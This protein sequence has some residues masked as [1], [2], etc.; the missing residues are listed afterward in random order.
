MLVCAILLLIS[1]PDSRADSGAQQEPP[2][3]I[4]VATY[5]LQPDTESF[6]PVIAD[7]VRYRLISRGLGVSF[8]AGTPSI[9]V[10][11]AQARKAGAAITLICSYSVIGSQMSIS[12]QWR[13][14]QRKAPPVVRDEKGPLDLMLDSVILKALDDLLSSVQERV[15]QLAGLREAASRAQAKAPPAKDEGAGAGTPAETVAAKALPAVAPSSMHYSLSSGF[16]SFI[17]IGPASYYFSVGLFPSLLASLEFSTP[18]G[19]FA[20]GI[21][22]GVNFFSA[23]GPLDTATSFLIPLGPDVRYEIGDGAPLLAFAHVSGGPALLI[24]N[25]GS[26]G[27]LSDFTAFLKSGIGV[28]FM[29]TPWLGVSL[30]ADYEVYFE[31]PYL[32]MG[33]SPTLMVSFRL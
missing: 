2:P 30:I 29:F 1:I 27:T 26:Q 5:P 33:F 17:P 21:Y 3:D 24:L 8:Q 9:A 16:A 11:E 28:S 18:A 4:L 7:A 19:R 13:D 20:V 25:T 10:L 32:I 12:L 6:G 31:M 14:I 22:A 15:R 23:T